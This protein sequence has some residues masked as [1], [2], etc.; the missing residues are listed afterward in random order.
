MGKAAVGLL[1]AGVVGLGAGYAV[2]RSYLHSDAFRKFLSAEAGKVAGVTGGFAPFRWQ[3]L[4][5][6]TDLFEATGDGLVSEVRADD[7]HTEIGLGGVGR[8]VWEI[9]GSRVKRLDVSIDARR[10]LDEETVAK[11]ERK[12]EKPSARPGWFPR[13]A[14]LQ[15]VDVGGLSVKA[16]LE[17]GLVTAT[18]MRFSAERTGGNGA[19]RARIDGGRVKLPFAIVPELRLEHVKARYQGG[20]VF[21]TDALVGAWENGRVEG[22]G[23]YDIHTRRFAMQGSVTGIQTDEVFGPDWA[24]RLT[25]NVVSD[26]TLDNPSGAPQAHGT[27]TIN[28]AVV[29]ALPLLDTLA[30]YADTRRFRVLTLQEARTDWR[31]K[32]GELTLSKLVL[33]SEGLV[34]LE[35]GMTIRGREIDGLFRLGLAPGTLATIP[36]AET[37]V[38]IAGERGLLW[39]PLHITGTL[40]DPKEDLSDRLMTAAGMRM[41]EQI[42]ET[43][44]KVI[45]F[46]QSM[47][48]EAPVKSVEAGTKILKEG[49]KAVRDVT[50]ILGGL[51]GGEETGKEKEDDQ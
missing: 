36:G 18:G 37:L 12:S 42:P 45:K 19:Y 8:G 3:G 51:L 44:E 41:F 47:L 2:I 24:K 4:A 46:T 31:W 48:G 40:D 34:R 33:S 9:N 14:E 22:T 25:G 49:T 32:K 39:A 5:V 27:L 29:T 15:G 30:A 50:G 23:E 11:E 6:D 28:N 38:F 35:G 7:L 16:L 13:D 20:Q 26:F 21:L 10:K 17:E 1:V 43:G